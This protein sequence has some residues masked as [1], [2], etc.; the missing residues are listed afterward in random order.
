MITANSATD[1][2]TWTI[3]TVN[4][5]VSISGALARRPRADASVW[6]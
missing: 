4:P 3:D 2:A 6:S 5:S 1:S